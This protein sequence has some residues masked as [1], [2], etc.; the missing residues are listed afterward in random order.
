MKLSIDKAFTNLAST[1]WNVVL[2]ASDAL[3]DLYKLEPNFFIVQRL[4]YSLS[5]EAEF[6]RNGA[7]L[8]L[9]E[10]SHDYSVQPL[11]DSILQFM[12][13]S[14]IST[15]VYALEN[16]NCSNHFDDIIAL[17]FSTHWDT[18]LSALN[19]LKNQQF[20]IDDSD[21][22]NALDQVDKYKTNENYD[23]DLAILLTEFLNSLFC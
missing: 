7:A 15:L 9:R 8:A 4:V 12:N 19:I 23:G 22:Y 17:V 2:T 5:S 14:N 13:Q 1:D 16:L 18:R 6:E 10:I 11:F 20:W 3:V 21:I